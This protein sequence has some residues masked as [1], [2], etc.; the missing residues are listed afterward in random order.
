M[1]V[2]MAGLFKGNLVWS[3]MRGIVVKERVHRY[4]ARDD[5]GL[6]G[7]HTVR[8]LPLSVSIQY[9]LILA[10]TPTI[11]QVLPKFYRKKTSFGVV[12]CKA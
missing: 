1:T 6:R 11:G 2:G 10:Q 8:S 4:E 12:E 9:P 7:R 3:S 5:C